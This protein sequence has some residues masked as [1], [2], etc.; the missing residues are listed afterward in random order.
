MFSRAQSKIA[1]I[2]LAVAALATCLTASPASAGTSDGAANPYETFDVSVSFRI[3]AIDTVGDACGGPEFNFW[4][5]IQDH[6][7]QL[8]MQPLDVIN[9]KTLGMGRWGRSAAADAGQGLNEMM[10]ESPP[11]VRMKAPAIYAWFDL[12]EID[13]FGCGGDN[14][15][16]DITPI[17]GR[18]PRVEVHTYHR[19]VFL[20]D[21]HNRAVDLGAVPSLRD[22]SGNVYGERCWSLRVDSNHLDVDLCVD[23]SKPPTVWMGQYRF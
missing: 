5:A 12:W 4:G 18:R 20:R 9:N 6:D 13:T 21:A 11:T 17:L 2:V 3:P 7:A 1:V 14:D 23:I 8:G 19:R 16:I 15:H 22:F 10:A